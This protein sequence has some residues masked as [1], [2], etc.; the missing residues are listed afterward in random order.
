MKSFW[1]SGAGGF[2]GH[3]VVE[4]LLVNT[5]ARLVLTDSLE[6]RGVSERIT[7]VLD[8][9]GAGQ[10]RVVL[11][12][13]S[14]PWSPQGIASLEEIEVM[15]CIAS[16]SHIDTS[17]ADPVPF[18]RN[19][20]DV[21]LHSLELARCLKPKVL[22]WL[23]TDEVYGPLPFG[24]RA[25]EWDPILPSNP[26]SA[27]KA[28]Q[29]ALCIAY[30]RTYG[31]PVVIVNAMNLVG[32]RQHAEKFVPRVLRSLLDFE[33]VPIHC[34]AA[35]IEKY[36]TGEIDRSELSRRCYL[37]ARN[38]ADALLFLAENALPE[39]RTEN[40]YDL[41]PRYN[42]VGE[43]ADNLEM[44]ERLAAFAGKPLLWDPV[45]FHGSRPGHDLAYGLDGSKL[46]ALGWKPPIPLWESLE[47]VT[48]WS[49]AH[50]QWLR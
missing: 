30:R 37:H 14:R 35:F 40:G 28:A 9:Y 18:V 45:D 5:D 33:P 34:S 2:V 15:L 23:S 26:Y 22:L 36:K 1:I 12:D 20:V 29:E 46:A 17:I 49:L 7:E 24:H 16:M 31:V 10:A 41:L 21:A 32:E 50:P 13:L 43:E 38:L 19:N 47:K 27:S 42:V 3:H 44:A 8:S 6:H 11:H 4:H 39:E 48:H 25:K